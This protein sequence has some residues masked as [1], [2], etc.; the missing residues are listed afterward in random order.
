MV[1]LDQC[2][3]S[4][5]TRMAIELRLVIHSHIIDKWKNLLSSKDY[6]ASQSWCRAIGPQTAT[7]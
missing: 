2:H 7:S 6:L 1:A 3:G 4:K 5:Y